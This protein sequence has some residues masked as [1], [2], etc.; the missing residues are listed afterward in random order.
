MRNLMKKQL[1]NIFLIGPMGAGKSSIGVR[2]A[3]LAGMKFFDSDEEIRQRSGVPIGWIYEAEGEAGFRLR[4]KNLIAELVKL[5]PIVLSTGG[6]T[7][8]TPEN[9][10]QLKAHGVI[11]YLEVSL[12]EQLHRTKRTDTRP[13]LETPDVKKKLIELNEARRPLYAKLADLTYRT[14]QGAPKAIASQILKDVR[15]RTA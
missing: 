3:A 5:S 7:I 12:E 14:D 6:G 9:C 8:T 10:D 2:L 15:A 11:V 4:E 13:L 1:K